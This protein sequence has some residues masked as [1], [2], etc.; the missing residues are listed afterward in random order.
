MPEGLR[1]EQRG[2]TKKWQTVASAFIM[3]YIKAGE[4]REMLKQE[5]MKPKGL[6]KEGMKETRVSGLLLERG[7][8]YGPV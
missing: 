8:F 3:E 6:D 7:G 1:Q 2:F 4:E 5:A